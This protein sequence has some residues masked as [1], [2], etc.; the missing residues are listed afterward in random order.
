MFRRFHL[1]WLVLAVACRCA[2]AAC[3]ADMVDE[4]ALSIVTHAVDPATASNAIQTFHFLS[5]PMLIASATSD[6]SASSDLLSLIGGA[7]AITGAVITFAAFLVRRHR[8]QP[9]PQDRIQKF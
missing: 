1:A 2:T 7:L 8:A 3:A 4:R 9:T 6:S 5:I